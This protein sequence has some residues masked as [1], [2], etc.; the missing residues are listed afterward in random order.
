[1]KDSNISLDDE[2]EDDKA[3]LED[4]RTIVVKTALLIDAQRTSETDF[5]SESGLVI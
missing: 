3:T 2:L 5:T 4:T 1:M